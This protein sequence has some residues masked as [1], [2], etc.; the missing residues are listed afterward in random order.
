[1]PT[2]VDDLLYQHGAIRKSAV[3][4]KWL[5]DVI[6]QLVS[7]LVARLPGEDQLVTFPGVVTAR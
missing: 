2:W 4:T 7:C 3:S 5:A 1:M 6:T